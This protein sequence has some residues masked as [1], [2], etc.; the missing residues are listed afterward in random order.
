MERCG[1]G[2]MLILCVFNRIFERSVTTRDMHRNLICRPPANNYSPPVNAVRS[3]ITQT[4]HR[5]ACALLI[6]T[7][8]D[9]DIARGGGG[10][11]GARGRK[12][13][14]IENRDNGRTD[15]R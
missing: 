4:V 7:I 3:R 15:R 2:L 5:N 8:R 11:S 1:L 9:F 13:Y 10:G 6:F 12:N 14:W